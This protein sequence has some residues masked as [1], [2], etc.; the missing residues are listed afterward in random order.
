MSP[1]R[2][3]VLSELRWLCD[4]APDYARLDDGWLPFHVRYFRSDSEARRVG[5]S[6]ET[7]AG[8]LRRLAADGLATRVEGRPARYVITDAGREA[9][10]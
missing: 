5:M 8:H 3:A 1:Q 9:L 4:E 2:R 10:R 6:A 7:T